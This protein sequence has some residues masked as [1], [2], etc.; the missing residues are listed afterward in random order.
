MPVPGV[1]HERSSCC[2][3]VA[4]MRAP[5]RRGTSNNRVIRRRTGASSPHPGPVAGILHANA[6]GR[7]AGPLIEIIEEG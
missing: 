5:I 3:D 7:I 4:G 1:S 6:S 2:N